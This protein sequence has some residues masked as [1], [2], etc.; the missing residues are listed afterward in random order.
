M[1]F[2]ADENFN[3]R[4]LAGLLVALPE[5]DVL[6]VQDTEMIHSPDPELLEW[7]AQHGLILLTHDV[8]TLSGYAHGRVRAGLPMP[9]VIEV[10]ISQG[11]GRAIEDLVLLIET[12]F[13][14][15]IENQVRYVPIN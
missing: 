14:E 6:R 12:G 11:I 10:N 5:I 3:G 15:E 7:A 2:L 13:P 4:V 8:Q 1:R 9:D